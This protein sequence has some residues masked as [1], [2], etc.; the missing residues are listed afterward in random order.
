M[1]VGIEE[2]VSV[3]TST[4]RFFDGAESASRFRFDL[5]FELEADEE[6]DLDAALSL[7]LDALLDEA[8]DRVALLGLLELDLDVVKDEKISS[9]SDATAAFPPAATVVLLL[10]IVASVPRSEVA[11]QMEG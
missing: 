9:I 10:P 4:A 1:L 11:V 2:D 3:T 6:V 5:E 8:S 7:V